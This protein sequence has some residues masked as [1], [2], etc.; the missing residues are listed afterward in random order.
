MAKVETVILVGYARARYRFFH[1][2]LYPNTAVLLRP[3]VLGIDLPMIHERFRL[4]A[5]TIRHKN[6]RVKFLTY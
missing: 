4:G 5:H 6:S 1:L 2:G 3:V